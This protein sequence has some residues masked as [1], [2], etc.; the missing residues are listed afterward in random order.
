[1]NELS[2]K[3]RKMDENLFG[4]AKDVQEA[5]LKFFRGNDGCNKVFILYEETVYDI[6]YLDLSEKEKT[7]LEEGLAT[8]FIGCFT[9]IA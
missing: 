4:A 9:V 6:G 2:N 8:G 7:R 3:R 5:E 1:M